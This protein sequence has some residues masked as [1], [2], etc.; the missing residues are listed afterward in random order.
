MIKRSTLGKIIKGGAIC[1]DVAAPLIAT[2]TQ[3]PIWVEASSE[4]TV[5]GLFLIF[6]FLSALPFIKQIREYFKSPSVIVVFA[7]ILI[8]LV[9]LRNIINEMIVVC[10]VGTIANLIGA[11]IYKVGSIVENQESTYSNANSETE[12]EE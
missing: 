2:I 7:V 8:F 6:A 11:G 1:I 5:S 3:F 12:A 10:F 4:A 9:A